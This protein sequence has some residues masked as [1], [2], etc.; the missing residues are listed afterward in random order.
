[1]LLF[2]MP[3]K[4]KAADG[5]FVIVDGVLTFYKGTS[6]NVV[7][8]NSV[9]EIGDSAFYGR[10]IVS[11][12][13][14]ESVT[15]IGN[16]AF[17]S[18]TSL[19][20]ITI[21]NSVTS[22]GS[23]AFHW[24]KGLF[25]LTIPSSVVYIGNY[26]FS[27]CHELKYF[28]LPDSVTTINPG[29][30]D[31]CFNLKKITI[32]GPVTSIGDE[33][34]QGCNDL[35]TIDI[36]DTVTI[37][38]KYAFRECL[39]GL[40]SVSIPDSVTTIGYGAF[41]ECIMLE[42]I[43][44][45]QSV[46]RIGGRAFWGTRWLKARQKENP[47]VIVNG[48]LI[49]GH[50]CKGKVIVPNSVKYIEEESFTQIDGSFNNVKGS[51]LT[52]I[53]I[54]KSVKRIGKNAFFGCHTLKNISMPKTGIV[55]DG[56]P[57]GYTL[58]LESQQKR[59]PLVIVNDVLIDGYTCKGKVIIPKNVKRIA[60]SAFQCNDDITSV[61]ILSRIE[62]IEAGTFAECHNLKEVTIPSSVV[63]IGLCAF[64]DC[65]KLASVKLPR[66]L[67]KI[68]RLAFRKCTN[69]KKLEI[70]KSVNTIGDQAFME[71][72]KLTTIYISKSVKNIG[73]WT[74]EG[75][76]W[77][78]E[79]QK[80]NPLVIVNGILVDGYK[81]K[82][83]V[84]VPN[85]VRSIAKYAFNSC[86]GLTSIEILRNVG[87]IDDDAFVNCNN[88]LKIISEEGSYAQV[89]AQRLIAYNNSWVGIN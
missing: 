77:L 23:N 7:I 57:F 36:P 25:E 42:N 19:Y 58:W 84:I 30:F 83:K 10:N 33:A 63:N 28:T 75:T 78:K 2:I 45:P 64:A 34:F 74:F 4:V 27:D 47:M 37:I 1:M 71:C 5:D 12:E 20:R 52:S 16:D 79:K 56:N 26:A 13:I 82:G 66:N 49:D 80:E 32:L 53:I 35:S 87:F 70:P 8:P 24:C 40:K 85:S 73:G 54:P 39:F 29:T 17:N 51:N 68:D 81:C 18:C 62:T 3:T 60:E 41:S 38:G 31:S 50:K 22:I 69:L 46:Q 88:K 61:T 76:S 55:L 21:P 11:V 6:K 65:E 59:N 72:N 86:R 48:T 14:P 15:C 89:Y 67:K 43:A 44:I 9:T